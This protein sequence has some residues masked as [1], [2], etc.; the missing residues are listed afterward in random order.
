MRRLAPPRSY[1]DH[2]FWLEG[3]DRFRVMR[4]EAGAALQQRLRVTAAL[5]AETFL[6]EPRSAACLASSA[7]RAGGEAGSA[8]RRTR[9]ARAEAAARPA[10]K[11]RA[12]RRSGRRKSLQE[13]PERIAT[14]NRGPGDSAAAANSTKPTQR[15]DGSPAAGSV[16]PT[17]ASEVDLAALEDIDDPTGG[18][19][20]GAAGT[21]SEL[22]RTEEMAREGAF[23]RAGKTPAAARPR[24][25]YGLDRANLPRHIRSTSAH[26]AWHPYHTSLRHVRVALTAVD[27]GRCGN[28]ALHRLGGSAG[29]LAGQRPPHQQDDDH[30]GRAY[31]RR[32]GCAGGESRN[33]I[34]ASAISPSTSFQTSARSWIRS[35]RCCV[36]AARIV[37]F[38]HNRDFHALNEHTFAFTSTLFPI[39][40]K[41]RISFTGSLPAALAV[42]W[43]VRSLTR[44]R[45]SRLFTLVSLAAALFV[46]APLAR[47]A[48]TI[49][50]RPGA[51]ELPQ[52]LHGDDDRNRARVISTGRTDASHDDRA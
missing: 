30:A 2:P 14:R 38:L 17:E 49:E 22:A 24:Y 15:S 1:R 41:S 23:L 13:T 21:S 18:A 52:A 33:S 40:G 4:A 28:H 39:I 37:V 27:R 42:R 19:A 44:R 10:E 45:T 29:A 9:P 11:C 31:A 48:A 8:R 47:L 25:R 43:F 3:W 20:P 26:H 51:K 34:A 32:T 50:R 5:R 16:R 46:C 36:A 35:V 6:C 12:R 7:D